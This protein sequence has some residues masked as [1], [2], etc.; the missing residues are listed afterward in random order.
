[1]SQFK[2]CVKL[3]YNELFLCVWNNVWAAIAKVKI[4]SL[5]QNIVQNVLNLLYM[6]RYSISS[7]DDPFKV[8]EVLVY[9]FILAI[10]FKIKMWFIFWLWFLSSFLPTHLQMSFHSY[11]CTDYVWYIVHVLETKWSKIIAWMTS[12]NVWLVLVLA[13]AVAAAMC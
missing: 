9:C 3:T 10:L 8:T 5:V 2:F 6:P 1:M 7:S 13:L 12:C 11:G 4:I